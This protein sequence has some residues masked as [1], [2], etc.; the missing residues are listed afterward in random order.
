M[1]VD[2]RYVVSVEEHF[3]GSGLG[4]TLLQEYVKSEPSWKL[5]TLG[6]Q[7]AFI[8]EVKTCGGMRDYF[9]ISG[10]K[11]AEFIRGILDGSGS[12]GGATF[13]CRNALA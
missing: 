8:H 3:V 5:F 7:D 1:L 10:D 12:L 4:N 13:E 9:G 2:I 6:I 11:V